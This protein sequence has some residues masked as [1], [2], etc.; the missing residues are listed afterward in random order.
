MGLRGVPLVAEIPSAHFS[1]CTYGIRPIPE[2]PANM[3]DGVK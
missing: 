1:W 3:R 2:R